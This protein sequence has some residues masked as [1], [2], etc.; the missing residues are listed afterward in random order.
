MKIISCDCFSKHG[1][2]NAK[3]SDVRVSKTKKGFKV[4]IDELN[5]RG[6]GES[7]LFFAK[8]ITF[9]P[10]CGKKIEVSDD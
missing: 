10:F 4:K 1:K 7:C 3:F 6:Y 8:D 5:W 2:E 9:C